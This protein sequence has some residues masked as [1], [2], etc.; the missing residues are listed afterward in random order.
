MLENLKQLIENQFDIQ[1]VQAERIVFTDGNRVRFKNVTDLVM[2]HIG[3]YL[4]DKE[5][6]EFLKLKDS[7]K[8]SSTVKIFRDVHRSQEEERLLASSTFDSRALRF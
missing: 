3:D 6:L 2:D 4:S 8:I 5:Q 1:T 7:E